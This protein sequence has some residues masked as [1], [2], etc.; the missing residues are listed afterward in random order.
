MRDVAEV[1]SKTASTVRSVID[2]R[3]EKIALICPHAISRDTAQPSCMV[4][5]EGTCCRALSESGLWGVKCGWDLAD[6]S[7]GTPIK[8]FPAFAESL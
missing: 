5:A 2:E 6:F 4:A 7:L 8:L 3:R 1:R